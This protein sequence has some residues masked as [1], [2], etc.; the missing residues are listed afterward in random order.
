MKSFY[1]LASL[2]FSIFIVSCQSTNKEAVTNNSAK[3]EQNK[4]LPKTDLVLNKTKSAIG[5]SIEISFKLKNKIAPDSI[6]LILNNIAIFRSQDINAKFTLSLKN[7][8]TGNEYIELRAYKDSS[9]YSNTKSILVLASNTP[10]IYSYKVIKSFPHDANAYTQG[11]YL[12]NG[13]FYEATGL[14]GESTLRK[15]NPKTGEV[16]TSFT[17]PST[18]FGEG[19]TAFGNKIVQLSWRSGIGFV[20]NKSDFKLIDKFNYST[21]GW[22]LTTDSTNL[23]MSDGT[24]NIYFLNPQDYTEVRRI[25]VYDNKDAVDYLNELEYIDGKIWANIYQTDKIAIINPA[26]GNVEAY[27]DLKGILDK[28]LYT[29]ETDVL[30]GIAYDK[31]SKKLYVTGKKWPLLFEIEL[32]EEKE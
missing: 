22:G 9:F 2:L 25:Q 3:V 32:V 24:N 28:K 18:I 11:L 4:N 20:Y 16:L 31:A 21:E 10:K 30:N 29:S 1:Y 14:K 6:V 7:S 15:V 5:D 26:V 17:V 8:Q 12:E 19:I 27:V 23:L 13:F